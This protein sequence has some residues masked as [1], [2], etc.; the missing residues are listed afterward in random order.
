MIVRAALLFLL[1]CC[2][3][4]ADD[5]VARGRYLAVEGDCVVCHTRSQG[6]QFAGG[7]PLRAGPGTV[8]SS[9]ITPDVHTGIG[10]WNADQFYTALQNGISA[11]GRHLYPA[12]PYVYFSRISRAD[13]DALFAYLRTLKPA[14]YQP[15]PDDLMF[16]TNIRGLMAFWNA[17]YLGR[18]TDA[19][20]SARWNRG[21]EIVNG[22]GHCGGCHSPKN[23]LFADKAGA[24]LQG[25]FVDGWFASNLS[26]AK[27]DGLGEW[28]QADIVQF[29][30]TGA[31]VHGTA[32]GSMKPVIEKS[33]SAMTD[34]DLAA[35]AGY[36]KSLP[37]LE[38]PAADRPSPDAM[39]NGQ[40]VFVARCAVCHMQPG[41][42][43]LAGNTL[44]QAR[45]PR[46][47]LRVILQGSESVRIAGRPTDFSMP[48]FPVLTDA[49]LADVSTYIRNSWSNR[50][51]P[52][53]ASDVE[54]LRK[55][56][57]ANP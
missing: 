27:R 17:L 38:P 22:I 7:Y 48:A 15:P 55:F 32:I 25:G 33:T 53:S 39:Y 41:Y 34:A 50:A 20:H 19:P 30:K 47:V 6:P 31:S 26:G 23:F 5:L 42:P 45:D 40:A 16:P 9:N 13:S 21:A 36:L 44:V 4:R 49:N 29:L 46:S 57:A 24:A 37:A 10:R 8:Y 11:D 2:G 35:V 52:V 28:T 51:Q 43:K 54:S 18:E 1:L 3:A 12:F 14:R 56:L